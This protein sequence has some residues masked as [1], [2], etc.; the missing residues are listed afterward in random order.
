MKPNRAILLAALILGVG[1]GAG[2]AAVRVDVSFG[3]FHESLTPYGYWVDVAPYG[4]CWY[5]SYVEQNWRPYAAG[6]WY[7]TDGGWYWDSEEP[8]AWACYHYGRWVMHPYYGWIWVPG[9]EWSS[10]WVSWREGGDYIGWAPLPPECDFGSRDVITAREIMVAPSWFV[11]VDVRHFHERIH[12]RG[13]IVNNTVII[14]QTV[15]ITR[16]R[17]VDRNII[18]EGPNVEAIRRVTGRP[19][20]PDKT[21]GAGPER[22]GEDQRNRVPDAKRGGGPPPMPAKVFT[23]PA[24]HPPQPDVTRDRRDSVDRSGPGPAREKPAAQIPVIRGTPSTPP[25]SEV[26][27]RATVSVPP[28]SGPAPQKSEFL[29]QQP[30]PGDRDRGAR[31]VPRKE[32]TAA[33]PVP[34]VRQPVNPSPVVSQEKVKKTWPI[35]PAA[36]TQYGQPPQRG[37]YDRLQ[38]WVRDQRGQQ[39]TPTQMTPPP[40]TPS[41]QVPPDQPDVPKGRRR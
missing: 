1:I 21:I 23:P 28:A 4:R 17:R 39:P 6:Q 14:N 3:V 31:D 40:T 37:Y 41:S 24:E 9:Y 5:P 10:A 25:A 20:Q 8:W 32:V 29:R 22:R 30:T 34:T 18:D 36:S 26:R 13:V 7:W 35:P 15:N 33:P 16:I 11:F 2:E 12:R 27:P 19:W 38:P